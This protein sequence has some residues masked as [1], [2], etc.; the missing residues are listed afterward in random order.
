MPLPEEYYNILNQGARQGVTTFPNFSPPGIEYPTYE[1]LIAEEP[2]PV[3]R[4][5]FMDLA[6]SFGAGGVSGLTWSAI[7]L[8]GEDWEQMNTMERTGWI[9]GEGASLFLPIGPFGLLGRGSRMVARGL[10]NNFIDDLAKQAGKFTTKDTN[11]ILKGINAAAKKTGKSTDEIV[12]GLDRN[13]QRGLREVVDD[14]LGIR[15]I[16]EL[17]IGGTTAAN[18]QKL[19]TMSSS[20]AVKQAFKDA[21]LREIAQ[22]DADLIAGRFVDGLSDGRYV[23]DVAE[24][25]ERG[26]SGGLPEGV[27][28]YLG[29]AAQDMLIMGI[30]SIGA[31]KIAEHLR[32]EAFDTETALSHSAMMSLAF[33]AIRFF[34]GGGKENLGNGI[35]A[36][37]NSY[38][39]TNYQKIAKEHGEDVVRGMANIMTRGSFKDI[40]NKG[41]GNR[42]INMRDGTQ[43]LGADAVENALFAKNIQHRMPMEHVYE[44]LEKYKGAVGQELRSKWGK[45]YIMDIAASAPRMG[46]GVL[47][48]NHGMFATGMFNDMEGPELAS[49]IFMSA[50]MTKGRGAWGRDTQRTYMAEF[51]PYFEALKLLGTKPDV[52]QQRM[53]TYTRDEIEGTFGTSFATDPVGQ[54][55]E[56]TF[57]TV[58]SDKNNRA[59]KA[60]DFSPTN[61]KKVSEFANVYN[62]IKRM[63][64]PE[65]KPEELIDP[66]FMN[67]K[68]LDELSKSIDNI[69]VENGRTIKQVG[70][71]GTLAVLSERPAD[72]IVDIYGKMIQEM[73]DFAGIEASYDPA[74]KGRD[75]IFGKLIS[76]PDM[77]EMDGIFTY[78]RVMQ[79]L[80]SMSRADTTGEYQDLS[81]LKVKN[82]DEL[83][84]GLNRIADK[85]METIDIEYGGKR[86][87]NSP[88]DNAYMD[89]MG[90]A[91]QIG[92]K[93]FLRKVLIGDT[94]D[95]DA[96]NLSRSMLALF[97]TTDLVDGKSKFRDSIDEYLFEKPVGE[98]DA[99]RLS[100]AKET[101]RPLFELMK[102]HPDR[103]KTKD[104]KK[105]ATE[106]AIDEIETAA[107]LFAKRFNSLPEQYRE[108]FYAEGM[109]DLVETTYGLENADPRAVH[110]AKNVAAEGLGFQ[111]EGKTQLPSRKF[112]SDL[113]R[114]LPPTQS[115]EAQQKVNAALDRISRI[116][117]PNAERADYSVIETG[118]PE[119]AGLT[120]EKILSV[121]KA[122]GNQT[123]KD[124][125]E[126]G[127]KATSEIQFSNSNLQEKLVSIKTAMENVQHSFETNSFKPKHLDEIAVQI[128]TLIDM[129][130]SKDQVASLESNLSTIKQFIARGDMA[131]NYVKEN[132]NAIL[133]VQEVV[134]DILNREGR[135]KREFQSMTNK[136]INMTILGRSGGGLKSIQAREAVE[137]LSAKLREL[138]PD[139][140]NRE[141]PFSEL[142][143]EY[144]ET[145]S[146]TK[147]LDV[148]RSVNEGIVGQ[149]LSNSRNPII[150][151]TAKQL[152]NKTLNKNTIQHDQRTLQDIAKDYGIVD[153]ANP[154]E[155]DPAFVKKIRD[156]TN[157]NSVEDSFM[158][159]RKRIFDNN[160]TAEAYDLWSKF[161]KEDSNILANALIN[162]RVRQEAR[163][164]A[165]VL[166]FN[167]DGKFRSNINDDFYDRL[168]VTGDR[169][170]PYELWHLDDTITTRT[171][172]KNRTFSIDFYKSGDPLEIQQLINGQLRL[173]KM[174]D[175]V[176]ELKDSGFMFDPNGKYMESLTNVPISPLI[177]MRPSPGSR[178]IFVATDSNVKK[179]NSDFELWFA[180]K[181]DRLR[182]RSEVE[183]NKFI[184]MFGDLLTD[185][186]T[187]ASLRLKMLM[188]HI[189]YTR[190]GQFD[191]WMAEHSK[192]TP[193]WNNLAKIESDMFKRGYLSDGG[194][195]QRFNEKTLRWNA[196]RH[197]DQTVR[198]FSELLLNN[199][200]QYT[201]G[202][203]AD[204]VFNR[205]ADY[206]VSQARTGTPF[207]NRRISFEKLTEVQGDYVN[208]SVVN[209]IVG[210]QIYD[211]STDSYKSL[212]SSMLDGAKIVDESLAKLLWAQKGGSGE[213]N[214][215]KTIMFSTGDNSMLGKGFAVYMPS[216]SRRM[217]NRGINLLLG[218]SSA[219]S[220]TGNNLNGNP[221]IPFEHSQT[222]QARNWT[223][224]IFQNMG[225]DNI[226]SLNVDGLGVQ[227]TSKNVEGVNISSSMFDW[228][229]P[230]HVKRATEWMGLTEIL[231]DRNNLKSMIGDGPDF[232]R[233][234]FAE[235]ESKGLVY[236][237]G[238]MGLTRELID[239][240][241]SSNN[242]LVRAQ[243]DKI[244]R[245]EDYK[246]L[247]KV[248]TTYGEDNFIVPDVRGNLSNPVFA[249]LRSKIVENGIPALGDKL[250]NKAIQFG[251]I[252]LPDNTARKKMKDLNE[253]IFVF[254]DENGVDHVVQYDT[255][256]DLKG[257]NRSEGFNF[258]SSFYETYDSAQHYITRRNRSGQNDITSV[259]N[260]AFAD[261]MSTSESFKTNV[262]TALN[263]LGGLI[264]DHN[265]DFVHAHRLLSGGEITIEGNRLRLQ[266]LAP[267]VLQAMKPALG[268]SVNA[269]PKIAKDQ[270]VMRID[271]INSDEM[272]GVIQVNA[273]D[274]RT[275]LQRDNDGDHLYSYLKMPHELVR[276]Y[277]RDMGHKSDYNMLEKGITP[278]DI[279][280]FGIKEIKNKFKAGQNESAIGFS[281]YSNH[282]STAKKAIG[283]II[284][285]RRALSWMENAGL[286]YNNEPFLKD[287]GK[288]GELNSNDMLVLD[289]MMDIFQNS[290]DIHGGYNRLMA[291]D[292]LRNYFLWGDVPADHTLPAGSIEARHSKDS[293]VRDDA[294]FGTQKGAYGQGQNKDVQRLGFEIILRTMNEANKM[295][296][297]TW[298]NAG[299]RSP[300]TWELKTSHRKIKALLDNPTD[301]IAREIMSEISMLRYINQTEKANNLQ[302]QFINEYFQDRINDVGSST[303]VGKF[304][305]NL[306]EGRVK[307]SKEIWNFKEKS[308]TAFEY[309]IG[310]KVLDEVMTKGLYNSPDMPDLAVSK[311]TSAGYL[312]NGLVDRVAMHKAFNMNPLNNWQE[313]KI[314]N[315]VAET[316]ATSNPNTVKNAL[317]RGHVRTILQKEHRNIADSLRFFSE[318]RFVNPTK[319]QKLE[320]RLADV[321]DAIRIIDKQAAQDM[322]I[323]KKN[324]QLIKASKGS[325]KSY[326]KELK[327]DALVYEINGRIKKKAGT[328]EGNPRLIDHEIESIDVDYGSLKPIGWFKAGD[329]FEVRNNKSYL[330]DKRPMVRESSS[331][332]EARYSEAWKEVTGVGRVS[333]R[334]LISDPV[335]REMF[336]YDVDQ[337]RMRLDNSYSNTIKSLKNDRTFANDVWDYSSGREQ[338]MIDAFM[339]QWRHK[340]VGG[341]T[342][343]DQ[344]AL[345]MRY[346][347]QPQVMTGK[348]LSDGTTEMPYYRVNKRLMNQMF[349]WGLDNKQINMQPAIKRMIQHVE[350]QYRGERYEEDL[351]S[352]GYKYMNADGYRWENLGAFSDAVKSLSNGWFASPYFAQIE[353][354]HNL[355]N[356]Q[357]ADPITVRTAAGDKLRIKQ[358]IPDNVFDKESANG[359]GC[360]Y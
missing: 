155:I 132:S 100:E 180:N 127:I 313:F 321:S 342:E 297:D 30:H 158:E 7:D 183:A 337:L 159:I 357:F 271:R 8:Q 244:L 240:G 168:H 173:G 92:A 350:K 225:A 323:D 217:T 89:F 356:R 182:D 231:K 349:N 346:V 267:D 146:W 327:V 236:T 282:L 287:I 352:E 156:R 95:I 33:P 5:T 261:K 53:A 152:W 227:F 232:I 310:G 329:K 201:V 47:A 162:G 198:D 71:E 118:R 203:I 49:H 22:R 172:K 221:I 46:L 188:Q 331:T 222:G 106:I 34:P 343:M 285:S 243:L 45:N 112:V 187:N 116:L 257:P 250:H 67:K 56:K 359:K 19:L 147:A 324:L 216:I 345:L 178:I 320:S 209:E 148:V 44:I 249:E 302:R 98:K 196:Q 238:A 28:K 93:N 96:G 262:K 37:W 136:I 289:R 292:A 143:M 332:V 223:R 307:P 69:E 325:T 10:G 300:E 328:K 50:I 248:P 145:G 12:S 339:G 224:D 39:G 264:R 326:P 175:L 291:K 82:I 48:M 220:F 207:D 263:E 134:A 181:A 284:S 154:N 20:T 97:N 252:A 52:L 63:R 107:G 11:E 283:S 72:R 200:M 360:L 166:E 233:A 14:D 81:T 229:S 140:M 126:N 296:N 177:Y 94:S 4:G 274:L 110:V 60:G 272:N 41:M 115:L 57:D 142:V 84:S 131:E 208:N 219:K 299:S 61:H 87:Y 318:E 174:T 51:T 114:D 76:G 306:R 186:N 245:N 150:A 66:R 151:E 185:G 277:A 169:N 351:M 85:W 109:V 260:T 99:A 149:V 312:V 21:G 212:K 213:W 293:I 247:T 122:I 108:N 171:F 2:E 42:T 333:S 170:E 160:P 281:E 335:D 31:G 226:M 314:P 268:A 294:P 242:P 317:T 275:T 80:N 355:L 164:K 315:L 344:A 101:L 32:G 83:S 215:A 288:K 55:I 206:T 256:K 26:I 269:I 202:V 197:P 301:F 205:H 176:K 259:E 86:L 38:K 241:I 9:L 161:I 68:A 91:S 27:S 214:G 117:G 251:G 153:R 265:L 230:G 163:I 305:K 17:G 190:A 191:T 308:D 1:G 303:Q 330:I 144:N 184:E 319:L 235:R 16:N 77:M 123:V 3:E 255:H 334:N 103:G 104:P 111:H 280:I 278:G 341:G 347:L 138:R 228:Q 304:L 135:A 353:A 129:G 354:S 59:Y 128:E 211:V 246:M 336:M 58:L 204:E 167:S 137:D 23:N 218:E 65:M 75:K 189:D 40:I 35:K 78:N 157:L 234:V 54:Q 124:L 18:A 348:Y 79:R 290:V 13:V 139:V 295:A 358:R 70:W 239:M 74:I 279:N 73:A 253:K 179:L 119:F 276:D 165:G 338:N 25:V 316:D 195:T 88:W 237:E 192:A 64:N 254:R 286:E 90:R 130:V 311:H 120:I 322:V 273:H 125:L 194:T 210:K 141:K 29:M 298:D 340:I 133:S 270:P 102:S 6:Q 113:A 36:Y 121:D 24:W 266:K 199:N 15:W 105:Q 62:M 43:Y 193:D 309:S 258:F